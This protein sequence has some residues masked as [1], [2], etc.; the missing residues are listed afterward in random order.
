MTSFSAS[1][2][3]GHPVADTTVALSKIALMHTTFND[4]EAKRALV[5]VQSVLDAEKGGADESPASDVH[6]L[7]GKAKVRR[8]CSLSSSHLTFR[9]TDL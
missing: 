1:S 7:F 2:K 3:D 9:V 6:T 4:A 8:P 5:E